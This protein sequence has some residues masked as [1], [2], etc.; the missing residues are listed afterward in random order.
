MEV[1]VVLRRLDAPPQCLAADGQQTLRLQRDLA[2]GIGDAGV[3]AEPFQPQADVDA[4]DV[5]LLQHA[6][7][8]QAV[9]DLVVDRGADDAGE[10]GVFALAAAVPFVERLR[11]LLIDVVFDQAVKLLEGYAGLDVL[12]ENSKA[13]GD[14]AAGCAHPG[15]FFGVFRS[16]QDGV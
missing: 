10:G 6:A 11:T 4:D 14:Q 1:V 2:H 13:L 8:G 15:Q 12:F 16:H 7:V 5:P 9:A 3:A